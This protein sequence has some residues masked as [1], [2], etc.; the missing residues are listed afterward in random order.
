MLASVT[1]GAAFVSNGG[2]VPRRA[3][4]L[5][6]RGRQDDGALLT[7]IDECMS[8]DAGDVDG[9]S[10]SVDETCAVYVAP[11]AY[12]PPHATVAPA[13]SRNVTVRSDEDAAAQH[14]M[15]VPSL[16][17]VVQWLP[18]MYDANPSPGRTR[19]ATTT[20]HESAREAMARP[21]RATS[22]ASAPRN[23]RSPCS[24]PAAHPEFAGDIIRA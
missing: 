14:M 18:H 23:T 19:H 11:G 4:L 16:I 13:L 22:A 24:T 3:S 7:R 21:A 15:V 1:L 17:G 20:A 2:S 5:V 10:C 12:A 6:A 9:E 8:L